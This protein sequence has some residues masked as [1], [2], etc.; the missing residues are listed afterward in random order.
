MIF[1]FYQFIVKTDVKKIRIFYTLAI[2]CQK[3]LG[4]RRTLVIFVCIRLILDFW[5]L[6]YHT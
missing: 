2:E 3:L 1:K 5:A 4:Q 6:K